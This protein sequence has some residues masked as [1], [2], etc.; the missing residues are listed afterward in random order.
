MLERT[1]IQVVYFRNVVFCYFILI[2]HYAV[3][4]NIALFIY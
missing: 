2:L 1:V 4:T 3:G